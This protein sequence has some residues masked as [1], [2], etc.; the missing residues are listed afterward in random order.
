MGA[1]TAACLTLWAPASAAASAQDLAAALRSERPEDLSR[2]IDAMAKDGG[3]RD[4]QELVFYR[5]LLELRRD[6]LDTALALF[7]AVPATSAYFL[8]ARNNMASILARQGQAEQARGVLEGALQANASL[9]VLSRNLNNLKAHLA[10]RSQAAALQ[11]MEGAK[12]PEAPVLVLLSGALARAATPAAP[13][14]PAAAPAATPDK[15]P[16]ASAAAATAPAAPSA[17]P[18][19]SAQSAQAAAKVAEPEAAIAAAREALMAWRSAW[20]SKDIDRYLKA[21]ADDFVP[22]EGRSR[23]AWQQDRRDRILSKGNIRVRLD[24]ID[25]EATGK[26]GVRFRFRQHYDSDRFKS[27]SNKVVEM[28]L[29]GGNW[30]ITLERA[31]ADGGAR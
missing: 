27:S 25:A 28:A 6:R 14:T 26:G 11:T 16:A 22:G 31:A 12:P 9:A 7:S 15:T 10:N 8:D 5:G 24:R 19:K 3:A 18:V 23:E 2:V 20:E 29:R 4:A 21:Y 13:A 30:R 1:L 17:Q